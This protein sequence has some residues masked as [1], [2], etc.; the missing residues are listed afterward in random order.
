MRL[1]SRALPKVMKSNFLSSGIKLRIPRAVDLLVVGEVGKCYW[2]THSQASERKR[3]KERSRVSWH[4]PRSKAHRLAR[5]VAAYFMAH[6]SSRVITI[7][8]LMPNTQR[9]SEKLLFKKIYTY[10]SVKMR[11]KTKTDSVPLNTYPMDWNN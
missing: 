6:F 1:K 5:L 10:T 8:R 11:K 9:S 2:N 7:F 3:E 4:W